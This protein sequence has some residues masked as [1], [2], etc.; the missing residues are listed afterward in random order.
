M[1][2]SRGFLKFTRENPARRPVGER[3]LDWKEFDLPMADHAL[4]NQAGRCMDCGVPFCQSNTGCPLGNMIPQWNDLIHRGL[5][6]EAISALHMTNN[7]PEFTGKLCPAPCESAC[8]LGIQDNPV[9][10][11]TIEL[12]I[13]DYAFAQG[14][15]LPR[16]PVQRTNKKIA[17]VG[18][19]PA[20]LA[21]AQELAR[22]GHEVTVF[23]KNE[24]IGGLLRLPD[25]KLEKR[26]IDRRLEQMSQEGVIFKPSVA[27]GTTLPLSQLM[28]EFSAVCVTV[29]AEQPRDIQVPGR[30]LQG[31]H[32]AMDYLTAQNRALEKGQPQSIPETMNAHG[33]RVIVIGGGDTGS[34]C[35][36]TAHRQGCKEIHQFEILPEPPRERAAHTPWPLWPLKLRS[37]H[38][39]EEGCQREWSLATTEFLGNKGKIETLR[40][41]RV[42]NEG[43]RYSVL[44]GEPVE[45]SAD[46]ILLAMGFVGPRRDT[47]FA[48]IPLSYND[49]GT[50][51]TDQNY[52][53]SQAGIFA[54]GDVR[55]GASLIVWAI[56]EGR[57]MA[58]AVNKFLLAR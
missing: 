38:A 56:A 34:D 7:F 1:G 15:V 3:I 53:T 39:H 5:W 25:F 12:A 8:V 11:K 28:R 55:R 31:I 26:V 10:I 6:K 43:G 47:L 30:D 2:D 51:L 48:E 23:E 49:N 41:Q 21:A 18:S 36:G 4:K 50:I 17:I 46:L 29:G 22:V 37:S 40:A 16:R 9:A 24:Q 57:M 45:I 19:G 44:P 58:K 42:T 13:V 27:V 33:K 14:W 32:F 35:I 52:M 20:G 54:A